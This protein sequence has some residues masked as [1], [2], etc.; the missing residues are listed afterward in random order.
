MIFLV[1]YYFSPEIFAIS[2]I[3][4][5]FFSFIYGF[6]TKYME[7]NE[8]DTFYLAS[9]I[10]GYLIII[11]ASFIYNEILVCNFC[12]L[13][14]NTWKAIDK[15]AYYEM[16]GKVGRDSNEIGDGL[17]LERYESSSSNNTIREY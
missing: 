14:E 5:P 13:N 16:S 1:V 6:I 11:I 12:G 8:I 7:K 10:S 3:I 4:S 15:K 17:K 2:Y 9:N